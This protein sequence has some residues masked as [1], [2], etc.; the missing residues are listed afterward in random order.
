MV[1]D[2]QLD[3]AMC[4]ILANQMNSM[5]TNIGYANFNK[6]SG[7]VTIDLFRNTDYITTTRI[8]VTDPE[9]SSFSKDAIDVEFTV[10]SRND[11]E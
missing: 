5:S 6:Y 4:Q 9:P 10:E 2:N 3:V 7:L 11:K 8:K 1:V